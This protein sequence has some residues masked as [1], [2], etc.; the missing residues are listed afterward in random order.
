MVH[1]VPQN[2]ASVAVGVKRMYMPGHT[3]STSTRTPTN[4]TNTADILC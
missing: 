2:L 3:Y 4:P 1:N